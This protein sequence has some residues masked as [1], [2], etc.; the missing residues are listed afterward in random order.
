MKGF[1]IVFIV[2]IAA[3]SPAAAQKEPLTHSAYLKAT[4]MVEDAAELEQWLRDK[5][6]AH[7]PGWTAERRHQNA[8]F[9]AFVL[10]VTGVTAEAAADLQNR[11]V[12]VIHGL[13]AD[14]RPFIEQALL[15]DLVVVG[16]VVR[17]EASS[18]PNDGFEM[19]D[20]VAVREVLKGNV[21]GRHVTIRRRVQGS[22]Q[23]IAPAVGKQYLL[24]LSNGMYEFAAARHRAATDEPGDELGEAYYSIYR[25][26]E[27]ADGRLL[28]SDFDRERT[29][30]AFEEIQLLDQLLRAAPARRP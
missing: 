6:E 2:S 24:L 10:T 7:H 8:A 21:S 16:D 19:S 13:T 17:S 18:E 14:R 9:F 23:D 20:L 29:A 15:A 12:D 27:M 22:A 30:R 5:L 25:I 4:G 11:G 1:L 3:F 28:W 26:Y